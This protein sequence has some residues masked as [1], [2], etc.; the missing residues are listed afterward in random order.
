MGFGLNFII[1]NAEFL[2]LCE[3]KF[4]IFYKKC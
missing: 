1:L 3:S 4:D 2:G